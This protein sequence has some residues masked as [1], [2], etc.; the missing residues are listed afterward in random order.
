METLASDVTGDNTGGL[1]SGGTHM[2]YYEETDEVA[3]FKKKLV[4]DEL[5]IQPLLYPLDHSSDIDAS[6][7]DEET[8]SIIHVSCVKRRDL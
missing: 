7:V 3:A 5:D 6:V 8:N 2:N 1:S 4:P